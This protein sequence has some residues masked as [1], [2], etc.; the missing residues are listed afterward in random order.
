M[1]LSTSELFSLYHF[2][3]TAYY[4]EGFVVCFTKGHN[5]VAF[6]RFSDDDWRELSSMKLPDNL[7]SVRNMSD[8]AALLI[9]DIRK[10]LA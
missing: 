7:V 1:N 5:I 2:V 10:P 3:Y 4:D 9:H 6:R 8:Q